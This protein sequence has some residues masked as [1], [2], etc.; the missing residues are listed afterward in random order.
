MDKGGKK[1]SSTYQP[2]GKG[3]PRAA[4]KTF[5][6]EMSLKGYNMHKSDYFNILNALLG[7]SK[8]ELQALAAREDLPVSIFTFIKAMK[9][10]IDEGKIGTVDSLID[11]IY[12]KASQ[13]DKLEVTGKD[14]TALIPKIEVEIIDKTEDVSKPTENEN[15]N[16]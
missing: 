16:K 11:R 13:S 12:G 4:W 3:R 9:Q 10:D 8:N 7:I 5:V 14:G 2:K 15:S 6:K 1:F